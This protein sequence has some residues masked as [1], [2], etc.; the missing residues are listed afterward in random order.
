M[1]KIEDYLIEDL[2][3]FIDLVEIIKQ[4]GSL[5]FTVNSVSLDDGKSEKLTG[6]DLLTT[7]YTAIM[8]EVG[9]LLENNE[10]EFNDEAI[11]K[12][13]IQMYRKLK[14]KLIE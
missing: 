4:E 14:R 6:Y 13:V 12:E 1:M 7:Y 9:I 2:E 5:A 10:C 8:V 3:N 11:D